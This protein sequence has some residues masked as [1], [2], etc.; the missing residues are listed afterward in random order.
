MHVRWRVAH[1]PLHSFDDH[2]PSQPVAAEGM[3]D[4]QTVRRDQARGFTDGEFRLLH[5]LKEVH[6]ANRIE[7]AIRERKPMSIS[8]DIFRPS[9]GVMQVGA[10][11]CVRGKIYAEDGVS[12]GGQIIGKETASTAYVKDAERAPGETCVELF[13]DPR[14]T[15]P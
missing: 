4:K 13:C 1:E 12:P 15:Q 5:V 9:A 11:Q 3:K 14:I 10:F 7:A 6:G 2:Q 8:C